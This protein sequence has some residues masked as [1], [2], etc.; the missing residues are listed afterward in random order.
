ML[1]K[2]GFTVLL[3]TAAIGTNAYS[4]LSNSLLPGITV[5]YELQPN[6]PQLFINYMFWPIDA[7]CKI[8]SEDE[9]NELF[10]EA[11]ARKGKINDAT[12][13]E[14]QTLTVVVHPNENL[15]LGADSGAKVQI[16]NRG[17]HVVK[18]TCSA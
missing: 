9:S 3:A 6:E 7:T 13:S 4:M 10:I 14:G 5:E 16:T 15:K 2:I 17:N 12:I 18:A 11:K 1:K 8:I